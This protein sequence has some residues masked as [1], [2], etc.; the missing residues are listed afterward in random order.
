MNQIAIHDGMAGRDRVARELRTDRLRLRRWLPTDRA[1]FAALNADPRVM[2]HFPA[3]LSREES[4]TLVA[5]IE[6]HFEQYGFGVWAVEIP[7][8][9][10]FA[11][12]IGLSIP[13][14]EAHFTPCV[15]I[16]WRLAAEHWGRGYAT[17]GALA[18][19]TFGFQTLGLGEI[20]S[21][22]VPGNL[23]SRRVMERIGMV[24]NP[25]DD[26]DHP[27]LP[28]GHRFRRHVL[29]RMA[30]P[31]WGQAPESPSTIATEDSAD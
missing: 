17:E 5:G 11:G 16:G 7:S 8:F 24:R 21:F 9:T 29:Y 1:P 3:A 22:T 27:A 19:L 4:D 26:F 30:R 28:E 12:F 15:E 20:V 23:R 6:A 10:S 13:R 14:F 18:A 31:S 25:A 2:E